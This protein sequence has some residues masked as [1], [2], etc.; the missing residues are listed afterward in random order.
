MTTIDL[1]LVLSEQIWSDILAPLNIYT[2]VEGLSQSNSTIQESL[3]DNIQRKRY[4]QPTKTVRKD[5]RNEE[6]ITIEEWWLI[7]QRHREDDEPAGI[8][9]REDGTIQAKAW[10]Y[11]GQQHR[12]NAPASLGWWSNGNKSSELW[13]QH[14]Q[15]SRDPKDGPAITNWYENGQSRT[16]SWIN[17]IQ[18]SRKSHGISW[19]PNGNKKQ[20]EWWQNSQ[21]HRMED[22]AIITYR[23]DGI[24]VT[25]QW[26][27]N[28]QKHRLEGPAI[29]TYR[30]DG[31]K[32][33]E[34]WWQN[35]ELHRD[36]DDGPARYTIEPDD[37]ISLA[38]WW[39]KGQRVPQPN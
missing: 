34:R 16:K 5:I 30:E 14:D 27:Q 26:R 28:G 4:K 11:L 10:Y 3:L 38:Q 31:T 18:G 7:G 9:Y 29:I 37:S 15:I 33:T 1:T 13:F 17:N 21:K 22:Q 12:D 36:P 8:K 23:E 19:W 6:I 24:K 2:S 25:E 32:E 39:V 20:E 35:D